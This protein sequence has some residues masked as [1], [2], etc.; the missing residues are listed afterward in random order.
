VN[1]G[2]SE[3]CDQRVRATFKREGNTCQLAI[4]IDDCTIT[5]SYKNQRVPVCT[6]FHSE[7]DEDADFGLWVSNVLASDDRRNI[8]VQSHEIPR[9]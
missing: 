9:V 4:I 6:P 3:I 5:I 7:G 1:G 2:V 8:V